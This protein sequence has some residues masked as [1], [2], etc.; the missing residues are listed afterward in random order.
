MGFIMNE[1]E[2]MVA[3]QQLDRKIRQFV[4]KAPKFWFVLSSGA[5]I[6]L[7]KLLGKIV[8]ELFS[9]FNIK[10]EEKINEVIEKGK[11]AAQFLYF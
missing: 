10:G 8:L 5:G 11:I 9:E 7:G 1:E 3:R 4:K 6:F 2:R